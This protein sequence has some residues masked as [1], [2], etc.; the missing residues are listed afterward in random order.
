MQQKTEK[1]FFV[2]KIIWIGIIQFSLLRTGYISSV[3]NVLTSSHKIW[4][5]NKRDF[6]EHNFLASDQL[7]WSGCFD[8]DFNSAWARW[9]YCLSKHTLK[10]D[11]LD[12]YLTTF[13]EFV[14]SKIKNLSESSFDPKC[15]KANIDLKNA[16]KNWEKDLSFREN[17]IWIAI[18]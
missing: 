16:G 13:S 12:I 3:S 10:Q 5:V 14:T 6:F 8:A 15:L 17:C 11:F 18:V 4:H 9:P 1:K 2:S 7:I